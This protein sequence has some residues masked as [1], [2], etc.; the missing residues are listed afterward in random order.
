MIV[1]VEKD[2]VVEVIGETKVCVVIC[3]SC[4]DDEKGYL[5]EEEELDSEETEDIDPSFIID[6]L[7]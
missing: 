7:E 2:Y 3:D 1:D 6:D 5:L 4:D